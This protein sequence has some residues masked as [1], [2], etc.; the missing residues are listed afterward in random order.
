MD[1]ERCGKAAEILAASTAKHSTVGYR[2]ERPS[3]APSSHLN[4]GDAA[5]QRFE[6]KQ[7][8]I[9]G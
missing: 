2:S 7:G 9:Y 4:D 8:A 6:C 3:M 5:K 1:P